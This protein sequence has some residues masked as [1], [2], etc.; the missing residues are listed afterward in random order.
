MTAKDIASVRIRLSADERAR[1]KRIQAAMRDAT[2]A[3]IS[4]TACATA[5]MRIGADAYEAKE[6]SR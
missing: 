3:E 5:L 6:A 4:L 1:L 2:H